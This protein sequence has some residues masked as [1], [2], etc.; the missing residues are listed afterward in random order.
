MTDK[1]A[2]LRPE[3]DN[4]VPQV[5]KSLNFRS[6]QDPYSHRDDDMISR[7]S[8]IRADNLDNMLSGGLEHFYKK[9]NHLSRKINLMLPTPEVRFENLSF[10]AQVPLPTKASA[11]GTVGAYME[12]VLTPWRKQPTATKDISRLPVSP[13]DFSN[14]FFQSSIYKTTHE[15]LSK[16]F[17]E[18]QFENA[19]DFK[20][21]KSVANL[22]RSKGQSEFGLSFFP[23]TMLLLNRQKTI[24]LRDRPLLWGKL[25]EATIVGLVL[26]ALFFDCDPNFSITEGTG[27][28]WFGIA[29]LLCYYF[30][31]TTLNALALHYIR[32]EKHLGVS[33]KATKTDDDEVPETVSIPVDVARAGNTTVS[34]PVSQYV[35]EEYDFRPDSKYNFMLGLLGFWAVVQLAIYLTLKYVSH[36]KR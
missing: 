1:E 2:L 36:L 33:G 15:A 24:W 16:G 7:Y 29:V 4:D 34:M 19:E 17:N 30:F 28:L 5:Y 35:Q 12:K 3:D 25:F 10:S 32:Y 9:Y 31:F 27:Y 18:H 14:L 26:G 11:Q 8:T 21:A 20:K 22:A 23:S 6:I 13:E